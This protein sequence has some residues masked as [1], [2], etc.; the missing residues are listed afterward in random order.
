M[1]TDNEPSGWAIDWT[2]F[3]AFMMIMMG[4]WWILSGLAAVLNSEFYVVTF[5]W[6]FE[7]DISTWGWV[8]LIVG[9]IV[10]LVGIFLFRGAVWERTVGVQG[11]VLPK[12]PEIKRVDSRP[13]KL[14]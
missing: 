10:L 11:A 14:K 13:G 5:R 1:T 8:H 12:P 4:I 7:F 3:T 6:I 9:I 2:A